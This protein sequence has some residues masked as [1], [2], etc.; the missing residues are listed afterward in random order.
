MGVFVS[1]NPVSECR[2]GAKFCS[3]HFNFHRWTIIQDPSDAADDNERENGNILNAMLT[4]PLEYTFHVVGK[5]DGDGDVRDEFVEQVKRIP[6]TTTGVDP[7]TCEI[8]P[9]GSKF[10]K[11]TIQVQVESA[12]AINS[13]Y[14]QLRG[15]ELSVMQF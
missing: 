7:V 10:T 9:R 1:F 14:D 15:L 13:I 5:T 3:Q 12:D 4:F 2:I 6:K 11:V 8:T